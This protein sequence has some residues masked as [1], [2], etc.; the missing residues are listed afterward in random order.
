MSTTDGW[1]V[2]HS[3]MLREA[4]DIASSCTGVN[5]LF[6]VKAHSKNLSAPTS[7]NR[8]VNILTK[9][10]ARLGP[11]YLWKSLTVVPVTSFKMPALDPATAADILFLQHQDQTLKSLVQEGTCEGYNI[12]Q[13]SGGLILATKASSE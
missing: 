9:Q 1:P 13:N 6:Q 10:A 2:K 12:H 3:I 4:W 11:E 7:L 8:Q 5:C